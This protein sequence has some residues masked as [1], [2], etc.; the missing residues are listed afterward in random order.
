M[1]A[2]HALVLATSRPLRFTA[3]T[4]LYFAQG[5]P[6]GLLTIALPAWLAQ[7]G[8]GVAEIAAYQG[9]V[10]LPWG[11]KLV[12]GPLMD[13]FS[14][15]AMGRRRPWV[16]G[17]QA[18]L[19]LAFVAL[20]FVADPLAQLSIVTALA[21]LLNTCGALQDVA[22]DGMAI[23]LLPEQ[24]RGRANA[25]MAF[26]QVAGFSGFSA[27]SGFLLQ[28]YGMGAAASAAAS[29]VGLVLALVALARERAG[30]RVLPWTRGEAAPAA[31]RA[32]QSFAVIFRGLARVLLLPMGLVLLFTECLVRLRDG[33]AI[34]V[35]PVLA[36]QTLGF[37]AA[38]Y[39][40]L[41]GTLGV[42]SAAL[43]LAIGPLIDRHGAKRFFQVGIAGSAL[44][45]LAFALTQPLWTHAGYPIALYAVAS[46]FGQLIFV[47]FISCAMSVCWPPV[48]ASQFAIYM[49]LSN[50]TRSIGAGLF[51]LVAGPLGV[52]GPFFAMAALLV[53]ALALISR[54]EIA[55]H[56]ERLRG[57]DE[58][59]PAH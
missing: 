57:L 42:A 36:T 53:G 50:L 19:T 38:G 46:G 24:E 14:F 27:L 48:A 15:P 2:M 33:I 43:G 3:F 25:F 29:V 56:R 6:I 7:R 40:S 17:A 41:Q 47:S 35:L 18:G 49:S 55:P 44:V 31:G 8:L 23:D 54:F 22:T 59:P 39:A 11:L 1:R 21:F 20:A 26:G 16:L 5:V 12:S 13:R 34:S 52:V 51:A 4:A 37:G 45:T 32:S 10:G 9:V 30:E 28:R 58:A